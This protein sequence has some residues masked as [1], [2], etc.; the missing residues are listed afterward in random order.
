MKKV[1]TKEDV[2]FVLNAPITPPEG[3]SPYQL[4]QSV[5][6]QYL[7]AQGRE[8]PNPMPL[9]PPVGYKRHKTIAETMREMI[10]TASEEAKM[11]GAET[12][13][14]ANDFDVDEDWD[15]T[16][17]YEHDFDP[18]PILERMIALQSRP[19]AP[20]PSTVAENPV[21]AQPA[22]SATTSQQ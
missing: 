7:D 18:D 16:T 17:P 22:P 10:R 11:A 1:I 12:E 20:A 14:E 5:Q 19:P 9:E 3:E 21:P 13:E 2:D 6:S 4:E 15:P 8:L